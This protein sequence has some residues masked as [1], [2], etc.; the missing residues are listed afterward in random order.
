M[1]RFIVHQ[2]P[3]CQEQNGTHLLAVL[4]GVLVAEKGRLGS[5]MWR[6][7]G[8]QA[9]DMTGTALAITDIGIIFI[10]RL[11]IAVGVGVGEDEDVGGGMIVAMDQG[12]TPTIVVEETGPPTAKTGAQRA[13]EE[14]DNYDASLSITVVV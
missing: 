9:M 14:M 8:T 4:S 12:P 2:L 13:V 3:L 5:G 11:T 1:I 10:T 6:N 7:I